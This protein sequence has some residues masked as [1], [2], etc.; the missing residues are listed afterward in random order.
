MEVEKDDI[1][2]CTDAPGCILNVVETSGSGLVANNVNSRRRWQYKASMSPF[3]LRCSKSLPR[4][5]LWKYKMPSQSRILDLC[6]ENVAYYVI[7]G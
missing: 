7:L 3:Q 1:S 4:H 2:V 6:S 5:F